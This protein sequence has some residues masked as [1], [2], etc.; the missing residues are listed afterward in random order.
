MS[1]MQMVWCVVCIDYLNNEVTHIF[2]S[3]E[4][5]AAFCDADSDRGHVTYD[6][7][8]DCPERMEQTAS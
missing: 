5:A 4:K 6:Y 2:S 8:L 7:V 3:A 1:D